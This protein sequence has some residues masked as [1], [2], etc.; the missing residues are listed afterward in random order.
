[1]K[2]IERAGPKPRATGVKPS[3][4]EILRT[5]RCDWW[6]VPARYRAALM[7]EIMRSYLPRITSQ[8]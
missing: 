1:M 4:T 2:T 5:L 8:R 7:A 6:C 3:S